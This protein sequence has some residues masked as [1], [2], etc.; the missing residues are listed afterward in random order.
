MK[1][2]VLVISFVLCIFTI[3]NVEAKTIKI[4]E[5][6]P[7][8]YIVGKYM[9]TR[10]TSSSTG[11]DG[12]LTTERI[13][14]GARTILGNN[15]DDM[16]IYY[17]TG[18]GNWIDAL[19]GKK[20]NVPDTFEIET[21]DLVGKGTVIKP[22]LTALE[23][24]SSE[25]GNSTYVI[26]NYVFTRT[27]NEASN[28]DGIL[29]TQEI[30]LAAK[31][32]IGDDESDMTIYYKTARGTWINALNGETIEPPKKY[33]VAV[34]DLVQ[35]EKNVSTLTLA[36]TNI[37]LTY[38]INGE[39][40]YTYDGDGTISCESSDETKVT[41][42]VDKNNHKISLV[43]I[44]VTE[45]D[46]TIT[47]SS[48]E[49]TYYL[50]ASKQMKVKVLGA[51][52]SGSVKITGTNTWDNTLKAEVTNTNSATL[53]Y[54]WYVYSKESTSN[55]TAIDG[56][57]E[58]TYKVS[59]DYVGK[60]IYVV[61]S[62]S[63]EN[64]E[65]ATWND[66]TDTTNNVTAKIAKKDVCDVPSDIN[67]STDGIVTWENSPTVSDYQ[68]SID[69]STFT[70]ATS[71]VDYKDTIT[72]STG[73]RTVYVRSKCNTSIYNNNASSSASKSTTV[74]SVTLTKG[75][76]VETV[77]GD[78]NYITGSIVELDATVIETHAFSNWT[79]TNGGE[80]VS[81]D[82]NYS[83]IID[84]STG[85]WEYT[86]NAKAIPQ[87]T[88]TGESKTLMSETESACNGDV[89]ATP[90]KSVT[91]TIVKSNINEE[92]K[93]VEYKITGNQY[94]V[95]NGNY[96]ENPN[97]NKL[98]ITESLPSGKYRLYVRVTN[99]ADGQKEVYKD[100]DISYYINTTFSDGE[101]EGLDNKHEVVAGQNYDYVKTLPTHRIAYTKNL[102][103]RWHLST[104][105]FS[106]AERIYG[107]TIVDKSCTYGIEGLMPIPVDVPSDWTEF[108]ANPIY[109]GNTQ[110]LTSNPPTNVSFLDKDK[111]N[112]N[113][114]TVT[115]QLDEPYYLWS[116][117]FTF[118]DRTFNCS[119]L[120]RP[121][122]CTS[123]SDSKTY[124][125]VPL[126]NSGGGCTGLVIG[127]SS[128]FVNTGNITN[129]GSTPNTIS[130][131]NI[132]NG[133]T[134]V[135]ENYSITKKNGTLTI[136]PK[137][138]GSCPG[139]PPNKQY[140]G[141]NQSSGVSC[142][143]GATAGGT[144]SAINTGNYTQTCTGN[145]NYIGSCSIVW[146]IVTS[147]GA[148]YYLPANSQTCTSCASNIVDGYYC[149]GVSNVIISS[150]NQ[151]LTLCPSGYTHS[152]NG[153]ARASDCYRDEQFDECVGHYK[154][155]NNLQ[156]WVPAEW[157]YGTFIGDADHGDANY[158]FNGR[159]CLESSLVSGN[160]IN[161]NNLTCM[162]NT[163]SNCYGTNWASRS[164]H[165]SNCGCRAEVETETV[166]CKRYYGSDT[167]DR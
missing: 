157:V 162:E 136:N 130:N 128:T 158:S 20:I 18:S 82:N 11:Y 14:L 22:N 29:T 135:S 114:Y 100:F 85:N 72:S 141:Y 45:E 43:P 96:K 146:K 91:Y 151:G 105:E 34:V 115:A 119:M 144:T 8:T 79:Q 62:A 163:H 19:T 138:I 5:I 54:Q 77:T 10:N 75:D 93:K 142:P 121:I 166:A 13:M 7:S 2:I 35:Q 118:E 120:K 89:N 28:Y 88:I 87:F 143:T 113:T 127:H 27:P 107:T 145:G 63:K 116:D 122:T 110:S 24:D 84:S 66:I 46:V 92:Y 102:E 32:I 140:T 167:C 150:M 147:C 68:I 155:V 99:F 42:S 159:K 41:C 17:K 78:G 3:Q 153:R 98:V 4:S 16:T 83:A 59:S 81:N 111:V 21:T 39:N 57:T 53:S 71:G 52:L 137:H 1:K 47:V 148:G 133:G 31:T 36:N 134:N 123:N 51:N 38:G 161:G 56:A 97:A 55:G 69:N 86:A 80:L 108:C 26:G 23:R 165:F 33:E 37:D 94:N 112:A 103:I 58:N 139:S 9:Y 6:S 131:I 15:L 156:T 74:Y 65:N 44:A 101:Y 124:D 67:I 95:N 50:S 106:D 154:I 129:V 12:K 109:N 76:A 25:I 152:D 160:G 126:T 90:T 73:S 117:N 40:T 64:Y 49:G 132:Y 125:G 149:T 61:V 104:E 48:T 30:M 60:Y 70:D 164:G